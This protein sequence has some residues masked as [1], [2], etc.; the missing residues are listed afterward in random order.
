MLLRKC[1]SATILR[2]VIGLFCLTASAT[3]QTDHE[4]AASRHHN[5][6]E[7]FPE[8]GF[9]QGLRIKDSKP[10]IRKQSP[11]Q[12]IEVHHNP[13][14]GR[15]LVLDGV[16]QLTE[17]DGN[18]YNEM[19][20]HLPLMQH[21]N[22][23]RVLVIGGGDGYVVQEVLKHESVVHVDH[24]DLDEDVIQVCKLMFPWGAVWDDPRVKLHIKD[25]AAFL[26]QVADQT[27]DVIIQDSSDPW[28]HDE[29]GE[30][31]D[32][33]S[34]VL[35]SVEHFANLYRK[36]K[37][38]GVLNIQ[39][40]SLQIPSDLEAIGKWRDLAFH[41]GFVEARYASI[42]ISTY[43]TGQIGCIVAEKSAPLPNQEELMRK[44][45][46]SICNAGKA[47][48]YYHPR[49]QNSSF[50]LPFWAEKEIYGRGLFDSVCPS[51]GLLR[52]DSRLASG[53]SL[54]DGSLRLFP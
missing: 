28:T 34:S 48:T 3:S 18:A 27:Y 53:R 30:R 31:V 47:T 50:D 45:F 1:Q 9:Y 44:R 15:I 52:D 41:V 7:Y 4:A 13:H 36:L 38:N 37:P 8:T 11:Y 17:R 24:V 21:P 19:M 12:L 14:F 40:E 2:L 5:I 54:Y 33:P 10:L 6:G 39:A 20:A 25:G 46:A 43:P 42:M 35:Y 51:E 22:P 16:L 29:I 26:D 32:L 49:L 23:K